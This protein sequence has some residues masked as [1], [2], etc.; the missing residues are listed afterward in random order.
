GPSPA[1]NKTVLNY[2]AATIDPGFPLN[3]NM[4][5]EVQRQDY[6]GSGTLLKTTTTCYNGNL[7]SCASITYTSL[8]F[9]ITE[10]DAYTQPQGVSSS[11]RVET[12][13]DTL[14]DQTYSALYDF[15]SSTLT[16]YTQ[17]TYGTYNTSTGACDIISININDH[18]CMVRTFDSANNVL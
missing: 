9:P 13:F 14:G 8:H 15:G 2:V 3:S 7:T 5:F 18:F 10:T 6:Q 4:M 1:S 17:T 16:R 11:S 12:Q